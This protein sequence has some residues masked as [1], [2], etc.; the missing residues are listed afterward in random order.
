M[1]PIGMFNACCDELI[2]W[3]LLDCDCIDFVPVIFHPPNKAVGRFTKNLPID[4]WFCH[5]FHGCIEHPHLAPHVCEGCED[6]VGIRLV[7]A[8]KRHFVGGNVE[9]RVAFV[10]EKIDIARRIVAKFMNS[11]LCVQFKLR[12]LIV[13]SLL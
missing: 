12:T 3:R 1:S 11:G 7:D 2:F 8:G 6:I 13:R 4:F 5:F 9:I 10:T